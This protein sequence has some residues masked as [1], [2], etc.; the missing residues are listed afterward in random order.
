M[1]ILK[2]IWLVL[3]RVLGGFWDGDGFILS[4]H[5]AYL[6]LLSLFPFLILLVSLAAT[7][8]DTAQGVALVEEFIATLPGN[9]ADALG[10]PVR[11]VISSQG[12]GGLLTFGILVALWTAAS[13]IEVI[14]VCI[15]KA[16]SHTA[17]RPVWQYRL[18]S[19]FI[20]ITC[21]VLL[22]LS[23][24]GQF[25]AAGAIRILSEAAEF[26]PF[27]ARAQDV[28]GLIKTALIPVLLFLVLYGLYFSLTPRSH[29]AGP[30]WPGALL[31]IMLWGLT[32]SMLPKALSYAGNYDVT[33]GSLA[34]VMITL[35]FFYL[36]GAG[37]VLGAQLNAALYGTRI[38]L[39]K[40]LTDNDDD[41][42]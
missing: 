40:V 8:G 12:G 1:K 7:F 20:V 37:F 30:Y 29:V 16:Y 42:F 35:L 19:I 9:V 2:R 38:D 15:H 14:R 4:G 21:A 33:Y 3:C 41:P 26:L 23:V 13:F 5:M 6:A 28:A 25:I 27:A 39:L 22:L 36:I 11:E 34:G 18:Q 32:S 31:T 17:G 10:G 24:F